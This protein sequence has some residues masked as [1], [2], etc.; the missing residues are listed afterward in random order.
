MNGNERSIILAQSDIPE[1]LPDAI[2]CSAET[3]KLRN[4]SLSTRAPSR[5]IRFINM[6]TS[7]SNEAS[8]LVSV[9][10]G[11]RG[12]ECPAGDQRTPPSGNGQVFRSEATHQSALLFDDRH[13]VEFHFRKGRRI[14]QSK[15][16]D[17]KKRITRLG[18]QVLPMP[19]QLSWPIAVNVSLDSG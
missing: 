7:F 1:T 16:V 18:H 12:K 5:N 3:E 14:A 17:G 2:R 9:T 19:C 6:D 13:S 8:R 11:D 15:E 4:V 10:S